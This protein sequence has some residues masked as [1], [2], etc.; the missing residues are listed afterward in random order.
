MP[1][2]LLRYSIGLDESSLAFFSFLNIESYVGGKS[3]YG[4]VKY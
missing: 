4:N 3:I 2:A 1:H